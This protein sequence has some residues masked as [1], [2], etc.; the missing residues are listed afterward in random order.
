MKL[1]QTIVHHTRVRRYICRLIDLRPQ[2]W[3]AG[4]QSVCSKTAAG[5]KRD[6]IAIF[7]RQALASQVGDDAPLNP[8]K[9]ILHTIN[10]KQHLHGKFKAVGV[11]PD[12]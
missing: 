7:S 4:F 9:W 1:A 10:R 8:T 12:L 6:R 2:E 5:F 3:I 11:R